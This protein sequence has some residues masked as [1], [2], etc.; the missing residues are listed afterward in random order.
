MRIQYRANGMQREVRDSV[1][2]VLIA[3]NLATRVYRTRQL[4]ADEPE[5]VEISPRTGKP[6]RK[7]KR[8]DLA[9]ED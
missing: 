7:Y 8:R 6:K 1:G 5:E 3:R 2:E 9:A 4:V